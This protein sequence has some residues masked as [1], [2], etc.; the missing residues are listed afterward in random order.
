SCSLNYDLFKRK[1][2]TMTA[3]IERRP[4]LPT[5]VNLLLLGTC[6]LC[7][8][9]SFLV[10]AEIDSNR[11]KQIA[12][13]LSKEPAGF[14]LPA[15]ERDAWNRLCKNGSFS[16]IISEAEE[17][18]NKPIPDLPDDLYLDF[19]R[20]GNRT[21]WQ[22]VSGR[23]RG[24]VSTLVLAE[25][26]ENKG[27]FVPAFEDL[28]RVLCLE[29]TWVLPAHDRQLTNFHGKAVDIDLGS[30]MLAWSLATANYL[31]GDKLSPE[32]RRLIRD[33]LQKRIFQPYRDMVSGKREKN[34]W[35]TTTNNWNAVCLAGVTGSALAVLDS[36]D[37]RAFYVAAAEHYSEN[38]LA[39][40]TDDGYCSEG[41]GYW[42]YGFGYYVMLSEMVLQ[43]TDG[44]L[45]LM[46]NDK[47]KQAA[48]FGSRIE[49]AN[50]VYPA[51]ADCSIRAKPSSSLMYYVSRHLG[52][53]LSSW[54]KV[55]PVS[56]G[57]SLYQSM[58]YSFPNSASRVLP[59]QHGSSGPGIRSWFDRAGILI[60]RPSSKSSC[61][62]AVA[63]KGGHNNEHHNH[64][65]VG[66]F[67]VVL[68]DEP[69]LLDPGGEVYTARTFSSRRYDSDVLNSFGHPV[70]VV[71][72]KLQRTGSRARGEVVHH[73]FTDS[74]DSLILD[75]SSAYD[76][77]QLKKLERRFVYSRLG[78]G[79][80]TVTD[81]VTFSRPCEFG[82]AL[83]TFYKWK[84]VSS[85]SLTIYDQEEVL[86]VNIAVSGA[87]FEVKPE[88]I[89]EDL[90]GGR[91]PTRLGIN[92]TRPV[93]HAV[94]SLIISPQA[95]R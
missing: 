17:L 42:N 64:N 9:S 62:L 16:R 1:G 69:L 58:M 57:G 48:Q 47:V 27:R 45:D 33:N 29:R 65:D 60:C 56:S 91:L 46:Q 77:P 3:Q 11:V 75:I 53:G 63:L 32:I 31:L 83:I 24:R 44:R 90:S 79:S 85:S 4:S 50:G 23:R 88:T 86:S 6:V 40:F 81:E 59:A 61:R 89:E 72:G 13:M 5:F 21:R 74:T 55:D 71:A 7:L 36:K 49:I 80:L 14:G 66:S 35:M 70:P 76:V 39:G 93:N 41:L 30:A 8:R 25:C 54:E 12:E 28:V 18:L 73:E 52:L 94:V 87:G 34:W 26:L 78:A 10:A 38:F 67:V 22:R 43:A 84:K 19:S 51:F 20:T 15:S 82:T 2:I 68:G 95:A 92:L 37:S